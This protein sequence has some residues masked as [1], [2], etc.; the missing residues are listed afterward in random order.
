MIDQETTLVFAN[1]YLEFILY[2]QGKCHLELVI[3]FIKQNEY[4][5]HSLIVAYVDLSIKRNGMII[6]IFARFI[7]RKFLT[8]FERQIP[9]KIAYSIH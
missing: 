5:E 7:I 6:E 2:S 1:S 8:L 4:F 3:L 9:L